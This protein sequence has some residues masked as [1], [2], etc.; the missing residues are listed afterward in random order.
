MNNEEQIVYGRH[1]KAN[2]ST[3]KVNPKNGSTFTLTELQEIVGGYIELIYFD[4]NI[5]VVNEE[6]KLNKLPINEK[7]TDMYIDSFGDRGAIVGDV[8]IC[9]LVMIE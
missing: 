6:G 2:G 1:I 3:K 7:A 9:P 8:I 4:T 5:M